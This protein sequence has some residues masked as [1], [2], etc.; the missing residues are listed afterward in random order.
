MRNRG[1][2]LPPFFFFFPVA[3]C[4]VWHDARGSNVQA[5]G[6]KEKIRREKS[7]EGFKGR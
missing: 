7:F 6:V 2:P 4:Y 1:F 3:P 5:G